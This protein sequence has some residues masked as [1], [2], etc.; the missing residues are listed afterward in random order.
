MRDKLNNSKA[1][2]SSVSHGLTLADCIAS[3]EGGQ[4]MQNMTIEALK[5]LLD[6]GKFHHAT[7][8]NFGTLWEGLWI[9]ASNPTV[10]RGFEPVGS[11]PKDSP[12]LD[13]AHS[14]VR[15][16]G[17]SVGSYGQG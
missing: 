9:Y 3:C 1:H 12:Q 17:I 8:R 14:L 7:Y 5:Q 16:T 13:E 11:F 6:S 10:G 4:V 15:H 2:F